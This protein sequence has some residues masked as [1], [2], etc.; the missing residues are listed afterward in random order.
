MAS[1]FLSKINELVFFAIKI[2]NMRFIQDLGFNFFLKMLSMDVN[3]AIKIS[4]S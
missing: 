2:S 4:Y 3:K 1:L